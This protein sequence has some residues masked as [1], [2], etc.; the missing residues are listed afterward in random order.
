MGD[1][2]FLSRGLVLGEEKKSS[3]NWETRDFCG[4]IQENSRTLPLKVRHMKQINN[5]GDA[6]LFS[7][8]SFNMHVR[9]A[10]L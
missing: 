10:N 1:H 9:L 4:E 3:G 2:G 5:Y 6:I 8:F 7:C